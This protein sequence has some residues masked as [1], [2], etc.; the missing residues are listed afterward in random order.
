MLDRASKLQM[1]LV[2]SGLVWDS[3]VVESVFSAI[4][5]LYEDQI[6]PTTSDILRRFAERNPAAPPL[7]ENDLTSIASCSNRFIVSTN[8]P[9]TIHL[10]STSPTVRFTGWVDPYDTHF[11]YPDDIWLGMQHFVTC[12]MLQAVGASHSTGGRYCAA[13]FIQ[14]YSRRPLISCVDCLDFCKG[15]SQMSLGRL[16]HL[17]Q[18]SITRGVLRYEN[19]VLQPSFLCR[20]ISKVLLSKLS[21]ADHDDDDD[22]EIQSIEELEE[23]LC[24]VLLVARDHQLDLSQ[25]KKAVYRESGKFLNPEKLGFIK[26]SDIFTNSKLFR[27]ETFHNT[28]IIKFASLSR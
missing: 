28:A 16:C 4:E 6:A 18:C 15:V 11:D 27:L 9:V 7:L 8:T 22:H 13:K 20:G 17:V 26:L 10:S 25:I 24:K 2:E 14:D 5:S 3:V 12:A 21:L 1:M 23:Y 19:N